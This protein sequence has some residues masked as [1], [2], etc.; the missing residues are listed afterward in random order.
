MEPQ[1]PEK[2][3][4]TERRRHFAT[5]SFRRLKSVFYFPSKDSY[6]ER[7]A[8]HW[9]RVSTL[10]IQGTVRKCRSPYLNSRNLGPA[11]CPLPAYSTHSMEPLP[12][13]AQPKTYTYNIYA[14]QTRS[15]PRNK[16]YL[17]YRHSLMEKSLLWKDRR[18]R[19]RP[20]FFRMNPKI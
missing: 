7:E 18:P 3:G 19:P 9:H 5:G 11:F 12:S 13:K 16:D 14:L 4:G 17:L 20:P 15:S 6:M 10:Y 2:E 1:R 8:L